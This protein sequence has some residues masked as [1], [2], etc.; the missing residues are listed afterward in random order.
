[1]SPRVLTFK[2]DNAVDE[3]LAYRVEAAGEFFDFHIDRLSV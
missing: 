3:V 2:P 1:V